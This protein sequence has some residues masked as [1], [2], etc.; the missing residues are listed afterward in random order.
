MQTLQ[1]TCSFRNH[2]LCVFWPQSLNRK[3]LYRFCV[4]LFPQGL[5]IIWWQDNQNHLLNWPVCK[6]GEAVVKV[7][8]QRAF[9]DA[10][11]E[12]E[13]E[14]KSWKEQE[15]CNLGL[16]RSSNGLSVFLGALPTFSLVSGPSG[17]SPNSQ[18]SCLVAVPLSFPC[19]SPSVAPFPT[20]LPFWIHLQVEPIS[21]LVVQS[22]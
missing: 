9:W 18:P 14:P 7:H 10:G 12:L 6:P 5:C 21:C 13:L 17:F 8:T 4:T 1:S 16:Q 11:W 15:H 3:I 19:H 20:C 2:T 22:A